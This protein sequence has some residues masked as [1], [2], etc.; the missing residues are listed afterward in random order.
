MLGFSLTLTATRAAVADMSGL[1]VGFGRA[2]VAATLAL[3]VLWFRG[4]SLPERRH[5]APL[6]RTALGVVIGFP[7]LSA[8]ALGS[9]PASH[10]QVFLGLSP[11]VTA[12]MAVLRAGERPPRA[13]WFSAVSGAASIAVFG[14]FSA[15]SGVRAADL[16]LVLAVVLVGFGYAEGGQLARELGGLQVVSWALVVA[17]PVTLPVTVWSLLHSNFAQ[18]SLR[19]WSGFAYVSVISMYLAFVAWYRG[20]A[21]G[22]IARL[23]QVQL[24]MPVLGVCWAALLLHEKLGAST[25]LSGTAVIAC[26]L[27]A[28]RSRAYGR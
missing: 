11:I 12:A 25:L 7:A 28:Q 20:L 26:S 2:V 27:L 22:K 18:V 9:V 14:W 24:A 17:L 4:E 16:L 5:I 19:A 13:F 3:L 6:A 23:S 1:F 21:L 10:A 8:L 15:G